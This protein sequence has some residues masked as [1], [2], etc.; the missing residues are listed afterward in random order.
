[1]I[2]VLR[3]TLGDQSAENDRISYVWLLSYSEPSF[4]RKM[5]SAVPFFYWH[6]AGSADPESNPRLKPFVNVAA[7]RP[8]SFENATRQLL[9]WTV[10][11]PMTTP[12]R[13]TSR[14]Y[15]TNE[16][17]HE[18]LHI[19]EAVNYL[20][21]A[22][23][24]TG[25]VGL[26]QNELSTL[27][28]R[29]EL[30]KKMLGGFVS[31]RKASHLGEEAEYEESRIRARNWEVLRECAER[32][33]LRFEPLPIAGTTD[34]YAVLW[35]PLDESPAPSGES[36]GA[37]WKILN[38]SNPWTDDRL[39]TAQNPYVRWIGANG[40]LLSQQA[41][42]VKSVRLAPLSVYSLTYPKEPLLLIDFRDKLHVRRHEI[43]QRSINE[44]TSGV[45]GISHFANWY[46]FV[47]ADLY[48]FIAGR[49]GTA[50][51]QAER[52]DSYSQFR[53]NVALDRQIDPLLRSAIQARIDS[54]AVNP[55]EG[56]PTREIEAAR[57]RYAALQEEAGPDG[58]LEN[59]LER[60]RRSEL[61]AFGESPGSALGHDILHA[62]TFGMYNRGHLPEDAIIRLDCYRR[63]QNDL[64]FLNTLAEARTPP[65]VSYSSALLQSSVD[66]LRNLIPHVSSA[67]VR[68][69][70]VSALNKVRELSNDAKL[71]D[72]CLVAA[73]EIGTPAAPA[74]GMGIAASR[75]VEHSAV[76]FPE[77]IQ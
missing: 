10:L 2:A 52:L 27:I 62:V 31:V 67:R 53:V 29:L 61:A 23:D 28:A 74:R 20:R 33:G 32:A 14:A 75:P 66:E 54:L 69:E 50:V 34:Q 42:G 71:R 59:L 73:N 49:H 39:K 4:G 25:G 3:D 30:R 68:N 70:A 11:D 45:L 55:M 64:D 43:A 63:V 48:D 56:A 7:P 22:P 40:E 72:E 18:R 47:A 19:E 16:L 36:L 51:S 65:E 21:Q 12:V 6:F 44:V 41:Q 38:I 13:A 57:S 76:A 15:R 35:F 24:S 37:I 1:M 77:T 46:Y 5:L 58:R 9:Q 60:Q 17:D 26:T 8:A